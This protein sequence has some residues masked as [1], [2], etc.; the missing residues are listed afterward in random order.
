MSERIKVQVYECIGYE[1]VNNLRM[2]AANCEGRKT[3]EVLF[4]RWN[5]E[6]W[7]YVCVA[8]HNDY[9]T[10]WKKMSGGSSELE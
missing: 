5:P 8:C 2:K 6:P 7:D 9:I 3:E 1:G 4:S 10:F